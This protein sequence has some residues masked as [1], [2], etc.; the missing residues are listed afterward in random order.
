[1]PR[2]KKTSPK[3]LIIS[4]VSLFKDDKVVDTIPNSKLFFFKLLAD[5]YSQGFYKVR[6]D[7]Q[8]GS[9]S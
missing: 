3:K 8:Q 1:M 7:G 2:I 9:N 4:G 5:K 6:I